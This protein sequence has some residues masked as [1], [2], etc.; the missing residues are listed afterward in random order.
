MSGHL[1]SEHDGSR[2]DTPPRHAVAQTMEHWVE[3]TG[4]QCLV[5]D[6]R[7]DTSFARA[8]A[9]R[10]VHVTIVGSTLDA[11]VEFG[12]TCPS[13]ILVAVD[14]LG[15]PATSF[16]EK[17]R[18]YGSPYVI[19]VLDSS[20]QPEAGPM[21][22][23]GAMAAVVR[24]YDAPT[25]WGVLSRTDHAFDALARVVF[26]PIELDAR[27]YTV[28]VDGVRIPDLPLKEFELLRALLF[29]A[30][31]VLENDQLRTAL[32]GHAGNRPADNTIAVHVR[33]LRQRLEGIAVIRRVRGR[34]YSL[35]LS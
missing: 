19:A 2:R 29:R 34:G 3:A 4:A 12:R 35:V 11:L 33:R 21:L 6:P 32:W 5:V 16:V 22:C 28:T 13:V 10:G 9:V 18:E 20:D 27:A 23:A 24:P 7:A 25:I 1:V 26:G 8:M 30:P 31:E 14:S 15:V 17:V